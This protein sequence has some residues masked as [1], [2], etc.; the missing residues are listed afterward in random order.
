M[1]TESFVFYETVFKQT[2]QLHKRKRY[3]EELE[4]YRAI[5]QYGLYGVVPQ[6]MMMYGFMDLNKLLP[7][8]QELKNVISQL[9]KTVN[10]AGARQSGLT[11]KK[12]LQ[13]KR[14]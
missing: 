9:L 11:K 5:A 2:E 6:M 4:L 3:D 8:F 1:N 10:V 12:F 13:R 14:N 7:L